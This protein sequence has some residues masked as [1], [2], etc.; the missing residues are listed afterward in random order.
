V[1]EALC[2]EVRNAYVRPRCLRTVRLSPA[3][4]GAMPWQRPAG[5][6][7]AFGEKILM[8]DA[9]SGSHTRL[10]RAQPGV[11]PEVYAHAFS[12]E[13]YILLGGYQ[14]GEE[15]HPAGTYTCLPPGTRHGPFVS[16]EGYLV[17]Q[18]RYYD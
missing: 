15:Y 18:F 6:S 16:T 2:L 9:G 10:V 13:A 1:L 3:A 8:Q 14:A 5:A 7:D 17:L 11:D 4:I 12:E